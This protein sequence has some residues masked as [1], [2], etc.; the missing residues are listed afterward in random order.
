MATPGRLLD[1]VTN[2]PGVTLD[3]VEFLVLDEGDRLLD[4]GF[5]DEVH[6]LIRA[7][8]S[9][10]Q[11]M[12]FSATMTTKV[13]DL[14]KLS[15]K[16]P[17][18]VKVSD[19]RKSGSA[20]GGVEVAPRLEQEFVRIRSGNEGI[21]REGM[22]LA[23]L[24]RTFTTRTIVFFD[25]K[26]AAHRLMILMWSVWNQVCRAAWELD[27]GATTYCTRTISKRQGGCSTCHRLGGSWIGY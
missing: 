14:V 27:T 20:E 25:T 7:C 6:E 19:K 10:R 12:L 13:D 18:R 22:L 21:N 26:A 17:V 9:E 15:L 23:L 3:D 5:Q 16:R 8:P 24:T 4:L 1:H 11:T 2:S